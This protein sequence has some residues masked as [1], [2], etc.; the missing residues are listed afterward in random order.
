MHCPYFD[1]SQKIFLKSRLFITGISDFH[2]LP[3]LL[4]IIK[5][6]V[7]KTL[8][9]LLENFPGKGLNRNKVM[10]SVNDQI[11]F[12]KTDCRHYEHTFC[13]YLKPRKNNK[14]FL[15]H[16]ISVKMFKKNTSGGC[17]FMRQ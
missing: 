1:K 7:T 17:F 13:H 6:Q 15:S 5:F 11:I 14:R 4:Y 9:K 8:Q 10:L 2:F 3:L 12:D 16:T